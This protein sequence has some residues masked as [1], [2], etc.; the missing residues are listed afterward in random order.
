MNKS[1]IIA[2]TLAGKIKCS[3]PQTLRCW[4]AL[5]LEKT[6]DHVVCV[7]F[8]CSYVAASLEIMHQFES[9]ELGLGSLVCGFLEIDVVKRSRSAFV[10]LLK[11]RSISVYPIEYFTVLAV[12]GRVVG[13]HLVD[14]LYRVM[15]R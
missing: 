5:V 7:L 15:H 2:A 13:L 10:V 14:G 4:R 3:R 1:A 12:T 8:A 11:I 6:G 9:A